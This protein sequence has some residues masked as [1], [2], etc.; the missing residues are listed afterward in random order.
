[1]PLDLTTLATYLVAISL[2]TITPG[3]DTMLVIRNTARG[4]WRDGAISS[5]GIWSRDRG[6]K[7]I[8]NMSTCPK[9]ICGS[10]GV[11]MG[12]LP[13]IDLSRR[14]LKRPFDT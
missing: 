13:K 14:A 12:P 10:N 7:V 6:L 5:L 2:L 11:G 1:M 4:G 9:V 3:V 8:F